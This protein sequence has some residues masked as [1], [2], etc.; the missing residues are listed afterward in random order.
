MSPLPRLG[1]KLPGLGCGCSLP[2]LWRA[3]A[4]TSNIG[5][6]AG[7]WS[8]G[9]VTHTPLNSTTTIT[10]QHLDA[11]NI[12]NV[13]IFLY[14]DLFSR[15]KIAKIYLLG[16]LISFTLLVWLKVQCLLLKIWV[17]SVVGLFYD[18]FWEGNLCKLKI[19]TCCTTNWILSGLFFGI[20]ICIMYWSNSFLFKASGKP[21]SF[22]NFHNFLLQTFIYIKN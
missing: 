22:S 1:Q 20:I 2:H 10:Q 12:E 3:S 16:Y 8:P 6:G 11:I 5:A 15:I 7:H 13:R 9:L 4:D 18:H 19:L 21:K 17:W 14:S